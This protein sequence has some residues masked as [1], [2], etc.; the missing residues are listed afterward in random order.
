MAV[1]LG[2]VGCSS[3]ISPSSDHQNNESEVEEDSEPTPLYPEAT[4]DVQISQ[5][6]SL[7]LIH[8]EVYSISGEG[9]GVKNPV[10]PLSFDD[11]ENGTLNQ[12]LGEAKLG[13]GWNHQASVNGTDCCHGDYCDPCTHYSNDRSHGGSASA[14]V[15]VDNYGYNFF[16]WVA[17]GEYTE[18]YVRY[19]RYFDPY[20]DDL[21][22]I[23]NHKQIYLY[24]EGDALQWLLGAVQSEGDAWPSASQGDCSSTFLDYNG[25]ARP[26]TV[27]YSEAS[28]IPENQ[29]QWKRWEFF[30]RNDRPSSAE[31][32]SKQLWID[33]KQL[34]GRINYSKPSG[35]EPNLMVEDPENM[36]LVANDCAREQQYIQDFRIGAMVHN[37]DPCNSR[38]GGTEPDITYID[39]LYVD[40]TRAR[41]EVCN[42]P[43]F[44]EKEQNGAHCEVQIPRFVWSENEIQFQTNQGTFVSGEDLW[45]FVVRSDGQASQ[46]WPVRF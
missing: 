46:G 25:Y 23:C 33:G 34:L 43:D 26:T 9:F 19:W 21:H 7:E 44:S 12:P 45:V 29:N 17:G 4:G 36:N 16:G 8:E 38:A 2:G 10:E 14:K 13:L 27:S 24:N 40:Q 42:V 18:L 32:G 20:Y 15:V 31:N 3:Q 11:F 5:V 6:S 22:N 39:D 41:I 28:Y 37:D 30:I 35:N 1:I